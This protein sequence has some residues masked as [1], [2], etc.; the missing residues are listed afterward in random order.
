M[1]VYYAHRHMFI[2]SGFLNKN[3]SLHI[4]IYDTS[5]NHLLSNAN[6]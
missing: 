4:Y 5:V 2:K 6:R 3:I 1:S